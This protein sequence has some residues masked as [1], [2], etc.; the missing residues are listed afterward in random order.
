M[1]E[2]DVPVDEDTQWAKVRLQPKVHVPTGLISRPAMGTPR[3]V[4]QPQGGEV[5]PEPAKSQSMPIDS[6]PTRGSRT[7]KNLTAVAQAR[8]GSTTLSDPYLLYK[9]QLVDDLE[10]A[11]LANENRLRVM[12]RDEVDS[13]GEERGWGLDSNDPEVLALQ[14]MIE[15]IKKLESQAVAT[16]QKAVRRHPMWTRW[17]R[18][19]RG[20]G[21]KQLGRLL[22]QIGDPY[23]N[24]ST[25]LPRTVSSLWAYSGLHVVFASQD[26]VDDQDRDAGEGSNSPPVDHSDTG[27]QEVTVNRGGSSQGGDV[28]REPPGTPSRTVG[29]APRRRRGQRANW[30]TNAKVRAYL[31]AESTVKQRDRQ[32][33]D[34]HV[35]EGCGCS[36]YRLVYE[37]RRAHTAVTHSPDTEIPWTKGHSQNDAL[38]ITSKAIL[39]DLW[40]AARDWHISQTITAP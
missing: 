26:S 36:V 7:N 23:I 12:V 37:R 24:V 21:E 11:R 15:S 18:M 28:D 9:A 39:K 5:T 34:G 20:V 10:R 25:G 40:R 1:P 38:R 3:T 19:A 14:E 31:I 32:C 4:E 16:L 30:S 13:D 2:F 29:V 22:S 35:E 8:A 27:A 33:E 6:A 17:G